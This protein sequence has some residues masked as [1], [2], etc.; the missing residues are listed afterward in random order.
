MRAVSCILGVSLSGLGPVT[1][2][3]YS[4]IPPTP[5]R[6]STISESRMIPRPPIQWVRLRH[7]SRPCGRPSISAKIVAPVVVKPDAASKT[8]S[9]TEAVDVSTNG[10]PPAKLATIQQMPTTA[11]PSRKVRFRGVCERLVYASASPPPTMIASDE[12]R[13]R[14]APSPYHSDTPSGSTSDVP[15]HTSSTPTMNRTERICM[16]DPS[17]SPSKTFDLIESLFPAFPEMGKLFL[18][19]TPVEPQ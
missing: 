18:K 10:S 16:A 9:V 8:A 13:P 12:S 1:S 4:C 17:L 2:A 7:M 5:S 3:R 19:R 14:N 6:G 11:N 15:T